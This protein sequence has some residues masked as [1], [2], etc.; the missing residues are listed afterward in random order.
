MTPSTDLHAFDQTVR[1]TDEDRYIAALFAPADA[2]AHL[3]TLYQLNHEL[4]RI[5]ETAREPMMGSIRLQWWRETIE[6][7]RE[8]KPR[9]YELARALTAMFA[10][11]DLPLD[12][13]DAMIEAREMDAA[14]IAFADLEALEAYADQTS[15]NLMR[16]ASRVLGQAS[17]DLP[18]E[19]GIAHALTGLLRAIPFHAAR[20]KVYLPTDLLAEAGTSRD[21]ILASHSGK[22]LGPVIAVIAEAARA[23]LANARALPKPDAALPAFLPA[24]AAPLYLK[25]MTAPNFDAFH[26]AA[27]VPLFR[28]QFAMLRATWRGRI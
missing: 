2:R 5:A 19:A 9:D 8:G 16:L 20:R 12:L 11:H 4:A 26:D 17:D 7:A 13:F 14:E 22:K 18:R 15:G 25:R 1:R 10:A 21:D 28:R 6:A 27:E 24:A 23:H 3:F